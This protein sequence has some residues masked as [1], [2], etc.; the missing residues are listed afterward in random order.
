M[1]SGYSYNLIFR[2]TGTLMLSLH[3]QSA[4]MSKITNDGLTGL[5][6]DALWLYQMA[7]YSH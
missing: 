3:R 5:S 2:H 6:Q 4:R 7:T 1:S